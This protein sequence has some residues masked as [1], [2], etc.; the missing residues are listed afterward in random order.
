MRILLIEDDAMI[1]KGLS[2]AMQD[3]GMSVD[4]VRDGQA[5]EDA[6]ATGGDY[7]LVLLDLGL[8]NKSG[9]D[10]LRAVRQAGSKVPVVVITA[11]D[12]LEDRVAGLDYGADDYLV[13]PFEIRELLARMRAVLR[14]QG[15]QADSVLRS[16]ELELDIASHELSYRGNTQ[17]LSAKEFAVIRAL[18]ERPGQI[19]SRCQLEDKIYGW[20]EEVESNAIDVLIYYIRK[21]FSKEIINNVRGAGWSVP[22]GRA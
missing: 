10:V 9:I 19:L 11:R 1:G 21:K 14:R 7:A 15:G 16:G 22:K 2:V 5:G 3:A 4:W 6:I 17:A 13:K 8:P 12:E 18:I 20:G